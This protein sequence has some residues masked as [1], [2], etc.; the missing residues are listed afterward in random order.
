MAEGLNFQEIVTQAAEKKTQWIE[1][2]VCP[3]LLENYRIL[4]STVVNIINI[5]TQKG[6]ITPDPY[7][8]EKKITS[9]EVPEDTDFTSGERSSVLGIR[10]SDYELTLDFI[11][12]YYKFSMQALSLSQIK[13]LVN[14]NNFLQWKN[15]SPN[16]SQPSTRGL[17]EVIAAF[18]QN[19]EPISVKILNTGVS[20]ATKMLSEI[21]AMLKECSDLQRELYK[22]QV[23]KNILDNGIVSWSKIKS[24]TD[25]VQQVK[26]RFPIYMPK[27]FFYPELIEEIYKEDTSSESIQLRTVVL[28]KLKISEPTKEKKAAPV[29]PAVYITDAVRLLPSL[30][31]SL[32]MIISKLK[33]NSALLQN[34]QKTVL[35]KLMKA[36][37]KAFHLKDAQIEYNIPVFDAVTREQKNEKIIFNQFIADLTKTTNLYGAILNQESPVAQKIFA[38]KEAD[39]CTFVSKQIADVQEYLV[40]IQGFDTFFK[41]ALDKSN[42]TKVKGLSMEITSV[43]S[44]LAKINQR[45]VDYLAVIEEQSQLKKLGIKHE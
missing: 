43:K 17:A 14:F 35:K 31:P 28:E 22:L 24:V 30:E 10:L 15:L 9:I 11:C 39:L 1:S 34:Q 41:S 19:G 26:K 29:N 27:S 23:R 25:A 2:K 7:K 12:N 45:K 3:K 42:K 8:K 38:Q 37:R 6:L 16:A 13:V 20:D 32:E 33:D 36:L 5:L 40:V 4:H 18:R 21:N 44:T